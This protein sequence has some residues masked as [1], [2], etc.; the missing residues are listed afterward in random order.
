MN[1]NK[2]TKAELISKLKKSD[3]KS[4]NSQIENITIINQIESYFSQI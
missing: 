3:K 2:Y 1:F 4:D